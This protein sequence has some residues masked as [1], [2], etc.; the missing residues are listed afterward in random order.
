M[1]QPVW[2]RTG[3]SSLTLVLLQAPFATAQTPLLI[4]RLENPIVFDDRGT[5]LC[6]AK[7]RLLV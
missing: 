1:K 6:G 5:M 4:E 3:W 2:I 7:S